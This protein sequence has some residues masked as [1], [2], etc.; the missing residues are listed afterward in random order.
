MFTFRPLIASVR[1]KR[2]FLNNLQ[3]LAGLITYAIARIS[4]RIIR[5][6]F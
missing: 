4:E 2:K 6:P 3:V 1:N 5:G